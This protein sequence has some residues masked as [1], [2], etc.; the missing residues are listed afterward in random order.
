M[1]LYRS[2]ITSCACT[3]T[4][5]LTSSKVENDSERGLST[6]AAAAGVPRCL[7]RAILDDDE[8]GGLG[9]VVAGL[10]VEQEVATQPAPALDGN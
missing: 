9:E 4:N 10:E 5:T 8:A 1:S 6:H 7:D 3:R 2:Q